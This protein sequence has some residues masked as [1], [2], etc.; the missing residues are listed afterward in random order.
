MNASDAD[1]LPRS[2][3]GLPEMDVDAFDELKGQVRG[4]PMI[5]NLWASWCV[6]CEEEAPDLARAASEHGDRIQFLGVDVQDNRSDAEAFIHR[7]RWT[8]PSVFDV[9]GAIM[10]DLGINGPPAT[11]FYSGTGDLVRTVPGEIGADDL[12]QGV[13]ELLDG[14][15]PP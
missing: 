13:R 7:Y 12:A 11:L 1:L 8:Y 2:V 3:A 9:P 14:T 4:T 5:V 15:D 10:S 6:P